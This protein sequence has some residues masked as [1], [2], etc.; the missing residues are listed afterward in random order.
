MGPVVSEAIMM[1]SVFLRAVIF[2]RAIVSWFPIKRDSIIVVVLFSITEPFINPI[3]KLIQRSPIGSGTTIDFS[4]FITLI[5]VQLL[6]PIL[7]SIAL[8]VL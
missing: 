7:A 4:L 5:L 6:A 3:R 2:A 1:F 8:T